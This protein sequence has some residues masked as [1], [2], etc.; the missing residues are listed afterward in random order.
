MPLITPTPNNTSNS[1]PQVD[2]LQCTSCICGKLLPLP[3]PLPL[4]LRLMK[5]LPLPL[6][7]RHPRQRQL[8]PL[9]LPPLPPLLPPLLPPPHEDGRKTSEA[10]AHSWTLPNP[11]AMLRM[12]PMPPTM[13]TVTP[14]GSNDDT[15]H[16]DD[17]ESLMTHHKI[18]RKNIKARKPPSTI[19]PDNAKSNTAPQHR[20]TQSMT[21]TKQRENICIPEDADRTPWKNGS[22]VEITT[23]ID[24]PDNSGLPWHCLERSKETEP[25]V[26]QRTSKETDQQWQFQST[27]TNLTTIAYHGTTWRMTKALD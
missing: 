12:P 5:P 13:M 24:Y 22:T 15:E 3:Q 21:A 4:L 18:M 19:Q 6:H 14:R 11:H 27:P 1:G 7:Y 17:F 16:Q 26:D 10:N 23:Q 9:L 2:E 8:L 20:I 25:N